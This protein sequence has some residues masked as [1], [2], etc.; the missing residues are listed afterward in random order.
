[1]KSGREEGSS[2]SSSSGCGWRNWVAADVPGAVIKSMLMM[3]SGAT[4][5]Y[6]IEGGPPHAAIMNHYFPVT[7]LQ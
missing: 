2:E 4:T 6:A 1:M 5:C 7:H 3:T